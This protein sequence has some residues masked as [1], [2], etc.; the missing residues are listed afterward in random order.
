MH[1]RFDIAIIGGGPA[2]STCASLLRK[3]NPSLRVGV[4]EKEKF[5]REHVGESQLPLIGTILQEMGCWDKVEAAE[6]PIKLGATFRWGSSPALWDFEFIPFRDF[7]D[8]PR[9]AK[10]VGQRLWTA[11]QVERAVYD[12]ILL[13]HAAELGAEVHQECAVRTVH[14]DE[15]DPD[16]VRCLEMTDGRTVEAKYFVDA[17][18]HAGV[19]R[20][21]MEVPVS[22]PGN[23]KNVAFWD[24]W[25]NAEWAVTIGRRRIPARRAR[26]RHG[27]T[28]RRRLTPRAARCSPASVR[29]NPPPLTPPH[30]G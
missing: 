21:A 11:F 19:L 1:E 6:F 23:I 24:Y 20:R 14:R 5:P 10:F 2:G 25:D 18:G 27:L 3:Y 17:S 4:F 30:K 28:R 7:R 15:S 12:K 26:P 13:D 22:Y 8:E 16:R 9:P 29:D